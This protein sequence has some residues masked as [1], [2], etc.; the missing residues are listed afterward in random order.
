MT[1]IPK[2]RL[3]TEDTQNM[4]RTIYISVCIVGG[5]S[6]FYGQKNHLCIVQ[7]AKVI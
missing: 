4:L 6:G 3:E 7:I 5:R 1:D 2:S